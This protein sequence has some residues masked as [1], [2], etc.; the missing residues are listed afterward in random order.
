MSKERREKAK[1]LAKAFK[2]MDKPASK[3]GTGGTFKTE[4]TKKGHQDSPE[5]RESFA[6]KVLS[7]KEKYSPKMVKK[8]H[9]YKNIIAKK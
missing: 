3:G 6:E 1:G 4:A 2:K 7:N 9:F 8:A 5:G